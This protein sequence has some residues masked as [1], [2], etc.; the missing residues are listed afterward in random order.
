MTHSDNRVLLTGGRGFTGFY[1]AQ[2]LM[3]AGFEVF[4]LTLEAVGV[5]DVVG[6][7]LD[8]ESLN[9]AVNEVKPDYVIHLAAI[10][11][12]GHTSQIDFYAVNVEGTLN[13]LEAVRQNAPDI[14]KIILASSANIYGNPPVESVSEN[15]APAPLNHYAMSKLAME[16]L[17]RTI[18]SD[19][20][21]IYTRPFNYTGVGQSVDFLVPKIVEH[22]KNKTDV[23][24]LGNLEV[25]RE[26]NDVRAIAQCYTQLLLQT[27]NNV[28]VVNLCSGQGYKLT[29]L[30]QYCQTI[31]GHEI[32]VEV[33]PK[34][35][36]PN[37][38]KVLIGNPS[39]LRTLAPSVNFI[40]IEET[41]GWML[42][43]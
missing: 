40:P 38:L 37:E 14:K 5:S 25:V 29:D 30:I 28:Q 12:V 10:A 17:S 27:T 18:F 20:P 16:M 22:F 34:F 24:Y 9:R 6:N 36:R 33:N 35:V 3:D 8:K 1:V 21:I 39:L 32:R 4:Q 7:L 43:S 41:L 2:S 13:L 11:F 26:F 42:S 23:I 31:T 15:V 19:L